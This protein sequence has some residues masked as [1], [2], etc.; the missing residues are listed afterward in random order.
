MSKIRPKA[1]CLFRHKG[2]VLLVDAFEPERQERF[3]IPVG[4][5]VEFGEHSKDAAVRETLEEINGTAIN[6]N[7]LTTIENIFLFDGEVGHEVVFVYEGDLVEQALYEAEVIHGD[8]NG[9]PLIA[10]WY[11]IEWLREGHV[12]VYPEGILEML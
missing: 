5:G 10:R 11:A 6:L 12:P 3:L 9:N 8:E 2:K 1:V 7:L 4:G